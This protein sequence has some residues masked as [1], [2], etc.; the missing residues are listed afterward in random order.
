MLLVLVR[1]APSH[2]PYWRVHTVLWRPTRMLLCGVP[3]RHPRPTPHVRTP[4]H[5]RARAMR[6]PPPAR[7]HS[8][9][10]AHVWR[11]RCR[12]RRGVCAG[13]SGHAP[14]AARYGRLLA[15]SAADRGGGRGGIGMIFAGDRRRAVHDAT[16]DGSASG[17]SRDRLDGIRYLGYSR[18][19]GPMTGPW[20]S[21][22]GHMRGAFHVPPPFM[23]RSP[24]R[25]SGARRPVPRVLIL[26]SLL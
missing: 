22:C 18:D 5:V 17:I 1:C 19:A 15:G 23:L 24:P 20:R 21:V 16:P 3:M 4:S 13:M 14:F 7:L 26:D 10:R 6:P 11:C 12:P 2:P 25:Y 9:G 8:M